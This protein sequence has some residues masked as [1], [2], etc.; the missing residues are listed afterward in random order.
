MT[1]TT[2]ANRLGGPEVLGR[3]LRNDVDLMHLIET[4]IPK[5]TIRCLAESMGIEPK[6]LIAYL[7]V[8]SRNLQRYKETDLLTD[9]VSDRLVALAALFEYGEET[10]GKAYFYDWMQ[11]PV[12]ALGNRPPTEFLKTHKGIEVLHD[13]LGRMAHGI[14]A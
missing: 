12:L 11:G 7:P 2:L 13:E 14:F 5:A 6:A 3:T 8:T 9:V 1:L 4:G 10:L